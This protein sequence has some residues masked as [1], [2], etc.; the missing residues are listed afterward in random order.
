MKNITLLI[1]IIALAFLSCNKETSQLEVSDLTCE[2]LKNPLGVD[3][4]APRL[5]WKLESDERG[6]KQTAY[7]VL[8]ASSEAQLADNTGDL[9]D[10]GKIDSDQSIQLAYAG[11]NLESSMQCFWQVMVWDVDGK[12]STWS[13][14]AQWSMGL[15]KLKDWTAMWITNPT[16]DSLSHPWLRKTFDLNENIERAV[17]HVN[18]PSYYQLHINGKKVT[19]HVLT[20]GISQLKKRFLVNTY[21]VTSLLV[22]GKNCIAVW[23]GPGWH[24][25]KHGN[26]H[27][28]PILRAQLDI[29]IS[30]GLKTINTDSSWRV[31]ESCIS[32]IGKW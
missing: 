29:H 11:K 3:V 17:I 4:L 13:E 1:S 6:Q 23:M 25:P 32:Q 12:P 10:T 27:N 2:Y 31:K 15:L 19:P 21:D 5:S 22:K 8:V 16:P 24:Q 30:T 14:P 7:R 20:P 28:S 18:T 9:W 26:E